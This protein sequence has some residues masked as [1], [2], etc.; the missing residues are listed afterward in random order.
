[1]FYPQIRSPLRY[2]PGPW[3][4][5]AQGGSRARQIDRKGL[6]YGLDRDSNVPGAY[7]TDSGV[8]D[9][10]L[11]IRRGR[12]DNQASRDLEMILSFSQSFREHWETHWEDILL[13]LDQKTSEHPL[14][15]H[16]R[17]MMSDDERELVRMLNWIDWVGTA[18]R[19]RMLTNTNVLLNSIGPT[20]KYILA[21]GRPIVEAEVSIHGCD[22]W[23]SLLHVGRCLN[24]DWVE[25]LVPTKKC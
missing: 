5:E 17:C 2:H 23:G 18:I 21:I 20:L 3:T 9:P 6:N 1:M 7:R 16:E 19:T 24:L 10:G 25:N 11:Q 14:E 4:S 22:Y 8:T 13:K 15:Y 12:L